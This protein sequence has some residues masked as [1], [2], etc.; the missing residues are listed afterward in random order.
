MRASVELELGTA[1]EVL[2]H[3]DVFVGRKKRTTINLVGSG[4]L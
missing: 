3:D 1:V 2:W 4:V